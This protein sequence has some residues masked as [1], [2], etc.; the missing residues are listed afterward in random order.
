M[1]TPVTTS[2]ITI[3]ELVDEQVEPSLEAPDRDPVE[4]PDDDRL[5]RA[6]AARCSSTNSTTALANDRAI[7]N[8]ASHPVHPSMRRPRAV[9][10]DPTAEEQQDEAPSAS[11]K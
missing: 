4:D 10:L 1:P 5:A 3:D 8:A 11:T 6:P 7:A 2:S 9:V